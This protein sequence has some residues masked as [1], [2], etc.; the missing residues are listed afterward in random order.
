MM[1][2]GRLVERGEGFPGAGITRGRFLAALALA[3]VAGG[4]A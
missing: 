3:G 4:H 2:V 1:E